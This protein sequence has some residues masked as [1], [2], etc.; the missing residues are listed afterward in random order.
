MAARPVGGVD[1]HGRV[2]VV[3]ER[4]DL[5]R[6]LTLGAP[7]LVAAA[8]TMAVV[9]VPRIPIMAPLYAVGVVL[10]GCGLGRATVA[11]ARG[12][13]ATAWAYNPASFVLAAAVVG[14]LVRSGIGLS[15]RRWVHV[16]VHAD[17][18]LALVAAV[19]VALL[20]IRQ[21]QQADLLIT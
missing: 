21:W 14:S 9:G 19:A 10:P 12:D 5:W 6:Y 2:R 15:T 4:R 18:R 20:W 13:V 11:L 17:R 1:H 16:R 7:L 3:L 8:T